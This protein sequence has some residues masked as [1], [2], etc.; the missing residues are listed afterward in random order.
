M[1]PKNYHAGRDARVEALGVAGAGNRPALGRR[2]SASGGPEA[3]A[4]SYATAKNRSHGSS[5]RHSKEDALSE[6]EFEELLAATYRLD[7]YWSLQ[8]RF[9][10]LMAGRLGL[11]AGEIAHMRS[12]RVD[13]RRNMICIPAHQPCE[14]G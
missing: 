7:E 3:M 9:V 10:V 6:R 12:S 5:T 11:R 2:P 1:H 13:F 14:S 8:C 4:T